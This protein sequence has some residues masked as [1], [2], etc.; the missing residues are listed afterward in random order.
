MLPYTGYQTS[1]RCT[2]LSCT[3]GSNREV[4][5]IMWDTCLTCGATDPYKKK[6]ARLCPTS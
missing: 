3:V 2:V 6:K 1:P 4:Y 5:M